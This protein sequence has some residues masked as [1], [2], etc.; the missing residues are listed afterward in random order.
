[1]DQGE[2]MPDAIFASASE[3][4]WESL[5][6]SESASLS[7]NP[8]LPQ[9]TPHLSCRVGAIDTLQ[10][11]DAGDDRQ[12]MSQQQQQYQQ[13]QQQQQQPRQQRQSHRDTYKSCDFCAKRK[14]RCDGKLPRCRYEALCVFCI[15][16]NW[17]PGY[18]ATRAV[19][20][21]SMA[22]LVGRVFNRV[23]QVRPCCRGVVHPSSI[24]L[25][26]VSHVVT[27]SP[28]SSPGCFVRSTL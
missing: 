8:Q 1:M 23:V 25:L 4:N 24:A 19:V 21:N 18:N 5:A 15:V 12:T 26:H 27:S 28:I 10:V 6:S 20:L 3:K 2:D 9:I 17:D 14:R 7:S 16:G 13:Q 11:L 22:K